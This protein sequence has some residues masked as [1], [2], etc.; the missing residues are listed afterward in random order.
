MQHTE[1]SGTKLD[2]SSDDQSAQIFTEAEAAK[3]LKISRV[4]LQRIRLRGEIAF[5]RIGGTRV[6]YTNKHLEAYL[7]FRERAVFR[8]A[9]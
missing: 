8:D 4:T 6:I 9:S 3:L 7:H 2:P 5:A 1:I